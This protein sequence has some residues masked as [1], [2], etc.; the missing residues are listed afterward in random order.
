VAQNGKLE[1]VEG[2]NHMRFALQHLYGDK[3]IY[4]DAPELPDY[5]AIVE[6][7]VGPNGV[8]TALTNSAFNATG[9][10]TLTRV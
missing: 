5:P 9:Q 8:A 10:G 3:F 4:E 1:I 2:P 7:T 6:F